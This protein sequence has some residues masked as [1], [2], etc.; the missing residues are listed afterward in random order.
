MAITLKHQQSG[1]NA[2]GTTSV[3]LTV[4]STT[5]NLLVLFFS[6]NGVSGAATGVTDN[7]NS[8]YTQINTAVSSSTAQLTAFYFPNAVTGVTTVTVTLANAVENCWGWYDLAG[9]LSAS[10]LETSTPLTTQTPAANPSGPSVIVSGTTDFVCSA[11]CTT[12]STTAVGS[13]FTGFFPDPANTGSGFAYDNT[14]A[15]GTY[16]PNWTMASGEWGGITAAFKASLG[17]HLL[18]CLGAGA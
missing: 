14:V 18:A 11:I 16:S 13:P 17:G 15:S 12:T 8:G 2:L 1:Q 4:T 10:P 9:A 5:G 7:K 3:P 6:T